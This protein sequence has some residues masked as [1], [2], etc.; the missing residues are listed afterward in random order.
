MKS[1]VTKIFGTFSILFVLVGSL[2]VSGFVLAQESLGPVSVSVLDSPNESQLTHR[3]Q[4]LATITD[5]FYLDTSKYEITLA[6]HYVT[7]RPNGRPSESIEYTLTKDSENYLTVAVD[8]SGATNYYLLS[9]FGADPIHFSQ[10]LPESFSDKTTTMLNRYQT[11]SGA[12][13]IETILAIAQ[14]NSIDKLDQTA[15]TNRNGTAE[16]V[17]NNIKLQVFSDERWTSVNFIQN[18]EGANYPNT[19]AMRFD[20]K[21]G[22]VIDGFCDKW[23]LYPMG[24]SHVRVSR[25]EAVDLGWEAANTISTVNIYGVG[26]VYIHLIKDPMVSLSGTVRDGALYPLYWL[27]FPTDMVYYTIDQVQVGVWGDTGEIAYCQAVGFNGEPEPNGEIAPSVSPSATAIVPTSGVT[28]TNT[29]PN[30]TLL[31][32]LGAAFIFV[33]LV[34]AVLVG[35]KKRTPRKVGLA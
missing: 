6:R 29:S 18:F 4:L 19:V 1:C 30:N 9:Y 14:H 23:L 16:I 8:L 5:L 7:T 2:F 17:E 34:A 28:D 22:G 13:Y 3:T 32:G 15:R 31:M 27:R 12:P 11:Q 26:D 21:L 33:I 35:V 25:E 20:N 10:S 24:D